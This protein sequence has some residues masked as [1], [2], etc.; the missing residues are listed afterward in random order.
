M[1]KEIANKTK[2]EIHR[3]CKK[4]LPAEVFPPEADSP[5]A[6]AKEGGDEGEFYACPV[7]SFAVLLG[8]G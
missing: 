2:K 7:V 6:E 1:P 3:R 4:C 8:C 5:W